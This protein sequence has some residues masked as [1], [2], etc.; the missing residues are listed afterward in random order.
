MASCQMGSD[1]ETAGLDLLFVNEAPEWRI[2]PHSSGSQGI[3]TIPQR[4]RYDKT[5]GMPSV[6]K[7]FLFINKHSANL[8]N[9]P[10]D[11]FNITSH[12]SRH[13]R[14]WLKSERQ[15]RLKSSI[16]GP[17]SR[18]NA[19]IPV[20]SCQIP[21]N[22]GRPHGLSHAAPGPCSHDPSQRCQCS[23][24]RLA[25]KLSSCSPNEETRPCGAPSGSYNY[26]L[27]AYKGNADP[28]AAAALGIGPGE[29]EAISC[30]SRFL[31]FAAWPEKANSVFRA[32]LGD[33][34]SSHISLRDSMAR[35]AELHAVI[36]SGYSVK[37]AS[38]VDSAD[39]AARSLVH[40]VRSI[41]LL[42]RQLQ[43]R[44][45]L[46]NTLTLVRLLISLDFDNGDFAAAR[47]HLRCIRAMCQHDAKTSANLRELLLISDVWTAM[48]LLSKPDIDPE[49]Y[50]PGSL[51][52]RSWYHLL[53]ADQTAELVRPPKTQVVMELLG[54]SLHRL[55]GAS[56]EVI[57]TKT[58]IGMEGEV[59]ALSKTVFWTSRRGSATTGGL[60]I[61]YDEEMRKA[62]EISD[63]D[64]GLTHLLRAATS[65]CL[66]LDMNFHWMD[67]PINYDFSKT[68]PAIEP[69]LRSSATSITSAPPE[70]K[71]LFA[72][73]CFLC[74]MGDD[75]FSARGSL[76]F[77]GW[78]ALTFRTTCQELRLTEP[79]LAKV[80]LL[81]IAYEEDIMDDFLHA[82]LA[83][84]EIK[85][86]EPLLPFSRWREILNH[87][88]A[89]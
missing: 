70:M 51:R 39:S 23:L 7:D 55:L 79:K 66:I 63:V 73:L 85:P 78:P 32:Q 21:A 31:V 16:G 13:H 81:G 54:P 41:E 82:V 68:F 86:T 27:H 10:A 17:L 20:Q 60:M 62:R 42:R 15:K 38:A 25:S 35:E 29:T 65:L 11:S 44:T 43:Q 88:V 9:N 37:A 12:V 61:Q 83:H 14:K 47:V 1:D 87:Y 71:Q 19:Q 48:A 5:N 30:A 46:A 34:K 2:K 8:E 26:G 49:E 76:D 6:P 22:A 18:A 58:I 80:M 57:H 45:P 69:V 75:I 36:A 4:R 28:F 77:S 52:D 56:E 33:S 84:S 72:W 74:A 53:T 59:T 50:N 89:Y 3:V 40:K 64:N 67:L 24:K